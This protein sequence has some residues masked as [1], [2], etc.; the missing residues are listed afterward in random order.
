MRA[1]QLYAAAEGLFRSMGVHALMEGLRGPHQ[2]TLSRLRKELGDVAFTAAW[3]A[4]QAM[5]LE[6]AIAYALEDD[7]TAD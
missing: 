4:G 6:Q 5:T 3:A 7:S 2:A 1:V